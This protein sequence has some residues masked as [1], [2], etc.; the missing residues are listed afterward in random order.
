MERT[1][2]DGPTSS[3][4]LLEALCGVMVALRIHVHGFLIRL[5]LWK[6]RETG[7]TLKR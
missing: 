2:Q 5:V 7:E 3:A 4:L 1:M 6:L